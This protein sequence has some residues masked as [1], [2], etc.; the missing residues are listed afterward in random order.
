M[1]ENFDKRFAPEATAFEGPPPIDLDVE[2]NKLIS[3]INHYIKKSKAFYEEELKLDKRRKRNKKYLFGNQLDNKNLKP[4]EKKYLD[5]VIREGERNLKPLVLS[6]LPD[7]IVKPG[8]DKPK[9]RKLAD[10]LS[11]AINKALRSREMREVLAL[12]FK[13]LPVYYTGVIKYRW[14]PMKGQ[15]GDVVFEVIHPENI[16][17]DYTATS[18]DQRDMRIIVHFVEKPIKEWIMLFPDKEE[19][20]KNYAMKQ[21][22]VTRDANFDDES[23]MAAKL[24]LEE[25]WFDRNLT[26][27]AGWFGKLK[28][29][30]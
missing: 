8:S 24:K 26:Q 7:L 5:N 28:T 20:L 22:A 2:D 1:A 3:F 23:V 30:F 14:D 27:K 21:G 12:G 17:M 18:N 16:L 15:N 4:Y 13:H 6:R 29:R 10:D 11:T 19:K 9:S 25:V